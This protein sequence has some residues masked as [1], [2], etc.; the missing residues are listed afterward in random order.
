MSGLIFL[1]L[2]MVCCQAS[3]PVMP[4]IMPGGAPGA[5]AP[6]VPDTVLAEIVWPENPGR[7]LVSV[8]PDTV[9][10]GGLLTVEVSGDA[11]ADSLVL[12]EWLEAEA[13]MIDAEPDE[14]VVVGLRVYRLA[15]FRL[16]VGDAVSGVITVTGR[17]DDPARMVP[18]REPR[19][20]GWALGRLL[21]LLGVLVLAAWLVWR[22]LSRRRGP[23]RLGRDRVLAGSAWP[24]AATALDEA[25]ENLKTTADERA[26]L[27]DLRTI[28]RS[29]VQ[30]RFLVPGREMVGREIAAACLALGHDRDVALRFRLLLE[31]L[32]SR[33]YDPSP[34]SE[35]WCRDR[36]R[37]FMVAADPV[38]IVTGSDQ[39]EV[40]RIW[41]RLAHDLAAAAGEGTP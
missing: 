30:D 6:V 37:D 12:P 21:L 10:L 41:R 20:P 7:Q 23:T 26:F 4:S 15:P 32:D 31:A 35:S 13:G 34:V 19:L 33:R 9:A 28:V 18:V 2:G 40:A 1:L 17:N 14:G 8:S 29:F 5:P 25:L 11:A 27:D 36:A 38:R 16:R 22:L 3:A 24:P 39:D